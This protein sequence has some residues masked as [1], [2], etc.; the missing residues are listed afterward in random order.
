MCRHFAYLGPPVALTELLLTPVHGLYQQ[1]WAPRRQSHGTVN[2][3]GFG[4]GW[5]PEHGD[6]TPARYRRAVPIWADP[7][8]PDLARS[9]RSG[10]V[11]AAVRDATPGSSP[12]ES[13]NAPFGEGPWLFSHNGAVADWRQLTEDCGLSPSAPMLLGLA[14]QSD[15]ALLWLLVHDRLRSGDPPATALAEVTRLTATVRPRAR[16]NLLLT[17]GHSIAAIRWGD[18]L[19]YR[20]AAGTV[21]VASEPWDDEPRPDET[22]SEKPRPDDPAGW[23][24]VPERSLLLATPA[25]VRITPLSPLSPLAPRPVAERIAYP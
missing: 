24:E 14:A 21:T 5:Y 15:S 10:A 19:W 23:Q 9:L 25:S 13:A 18:S 1:S 7:N 12:D 11:L 3:D 4:L 6:G 22:R 2:A 17:D 8:L 20:A 16:L